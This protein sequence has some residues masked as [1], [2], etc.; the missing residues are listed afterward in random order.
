[1]KRKAAILIEPKKFKVI[2]EEMPELQPHEV[3]IE[4]ESVGLCHSDVPAYQGDG[5]MGFDKKG[6]MIMT[7]VTFPTVVGHEAVGIAVQVGSAVT[8]VKV[9]DY[10]GATPATP[11]YYSHMIIPEPLCIPIPK[12]VPREDLKYCLVEPLMCV[13]N[14]VQ[15]ANPKFGDIVAVVGCGMMGTLITA[16][17]K[18]SGASKIIAVDVN[19][20]RIKLAKEFGATHSINPMTCDNLTDA[21]DEL[22]DNKGA[23]IVIEITG[24]LRGL[25]TALKVVRY[26]DLLGPAGRGKILIPS[27]YGKPETWDIEMGYELM[28]R[29]PILHSVHPLYAE[30]YLKVC[31]QSV[32]A[33]EKGILPLKKLISHEFT[34]DEIQEGFDL[35]TSGDF[36][37][38]KGIIKP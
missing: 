36:S 27:V 37:Y 11:G 35:M 16:G 21:V 14:I 20:D 23:D 9:G 29:S 13:T 19:D 10:I 25:K 3:L 12:S 5:G 38:I 1:M 6:H 24:S 2:E 17:L 15:A 22:T 31:R 8:S 30:D 33:F 34:L 4:V 7:E 18:N 32:E 26:G 28:Y